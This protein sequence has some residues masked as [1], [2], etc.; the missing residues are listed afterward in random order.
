M[1]ISGNAEV[2]G[3]VQWVQ[4]DDNAGMDV[5]FGVEVVID[6]KWMGQQLRWF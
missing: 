6:A 4:H 2:D 3:V 5:H 1:C